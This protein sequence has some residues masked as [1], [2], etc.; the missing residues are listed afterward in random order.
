VNPIIGVDLFIYL[1]HFRWTRDTSIFK[2]SLN[3]LDDATL[4]LI[5]M[6]TS[7]RKHEL[8]YA[9]P[10]DESALLKSTLKTPMP[11]PT[12]TITP[13]RTSSAASSAAG[14]ARGRQ[15]ANLRVKGSL[16]GRH[17][18]LD[19][20]RMVF[21]QQVPAS[22]RSLRYIAIHAP[23][24][25]HAYFCSHTARDTAGEGDERHRVIN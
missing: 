17:R 10:K 1:A 2:T 22:S 25:G 9:K 15:K 3:R 4:R 13:T 14:Y 5:Y 21:F 19:P 8:V 12:S 6:F 11:S 20:T 24:L 23:D 18:S 7:C 16:L